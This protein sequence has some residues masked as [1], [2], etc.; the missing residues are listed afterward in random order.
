VDGAASRST[1][2]VGAPTKV[3]V[4]CGSILPVRRR[5]Q[6]A[7]VPQQRFHTRVDS[8]TSAATC[9][10]IRDALTDGEHR[11][12]QSL[13]SCTRDGTKEAKC[14]RP[15][16]AKFLERHLDAE[17]AMIAKPCVGFIECALSED[18]WNAARGD[19]VPVALSRAKVPPRLEAKFSALVSLSY[20]TGRAFTAVWVAPPAITESAQG[21]STIALS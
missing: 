16:R 18:G 2:M 8:I 1:R 11:L 12:V 6:A 9:R 5:S 14:T 10:G 7:K 20:R 17:Q 13:N 3:R 15:S 19:G 21:P 4:H